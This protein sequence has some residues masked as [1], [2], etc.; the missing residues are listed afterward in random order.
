MVSSK[1]SS[2]W[3]YLLVKILFEIK[4]QNY[5]E[6]QFLSIWY[7]NINVQNSFHHQNTGGSPS[8]VS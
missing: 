3:L 6:H 1:L 4:I 2:I 5:L 7:T 8:W